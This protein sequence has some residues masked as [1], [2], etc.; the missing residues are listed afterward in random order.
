MVVLDTEA[1][2]RNFISKVKNGNGFLI[3]E[4]GK[5]YVT[6]TPRAEF[7]CFIG[8]VKTDNDYYIC[9]RCIDVSE[10]TEGYFR[11]RPFPF[12]LDTISGVDVLADLNQLREKTKTPYRYIFRASGFDEKFEPVCYAIELEGYGNN[13]VNDF[14]LNKEMLYAVNNN[15]VFELFRIDVQPISPKNSKVHDYYVVMGDGWGYGFMKG[16]IILEDGKPKI[17]IPYIN[18]PRWRLVYPASMLVTESLTPAH[19]IYIEEELKFQTLQR[20]HM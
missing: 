17:G 4:F 16:Y 9:D 19:N 15:F 5:V 6:H 14:L 7:V 8:L 11:I 3:T 1:D 13:I 10:Y 12:T 18:D 2:M 20:I